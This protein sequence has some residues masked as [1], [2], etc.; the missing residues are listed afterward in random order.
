M[1]MHNDRTDLKSSADT[2]STTFT[3]TAS[4]K[5]FDVLTDKLYKDKVLAAVRELS[6][7]RP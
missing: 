5:A 3:I 7:E 6:T 4:A 2:K 1:V